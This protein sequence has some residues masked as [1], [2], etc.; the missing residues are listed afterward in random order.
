MRSKRKVRE[1]KIERNKTR[2]NVNIKSEHVQKIT[3]N[4]N[5]NKTKL[6]ETCQKI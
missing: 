3:Q 2:N 4:V 5:K 6:K 1:K